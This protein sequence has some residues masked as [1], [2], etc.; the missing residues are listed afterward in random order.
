[1]EN[2]SFIFH[3]TCSKS[4]YNKYFKCRK[5]KIQIFFLTFFRFYFHPM[6]NPFSMCYQF[7]SHFCQK[8]N[9]IKF[10]FLSL[11]LIVSFARNVLFHDLFMG[12][13][14][15][16][17]LL[18]FFTFNKISILN[19]VWKSEKPHVLKHIPFNDLISYVIVITC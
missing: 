13:H 7:H 15:S 19:T 12:F 18:S 4:I 1:M 8:L 14:C 11:L 2:S 10:G 6:K 16:R 5:N 9:Q 3:Y 17:L